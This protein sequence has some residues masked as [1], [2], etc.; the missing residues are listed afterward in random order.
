MTKSPTVRG[1]LYRD[2]ASADRAN[3]SPLPQPTQTPK[4]PPPAAPAPPAPGRPATTSRVPPLLEGLEE[5]RRRTAGPLQQ[6]IAEVIAEETLAARFADHEGA[7]A[8]ERRARL[9]EAWR[10]DEPELFISDPWPLALDLSADH[11][12]P[13]APT[14]DWPV[15]P[16]GDA[17]PC[18]GHAWW[19]WEDLYKQLR[20]VD[21]WMASP[22]ARRVA[23]G[24]WALY[25]E[26]QD[27]CWYFARLPHLQRWPW[28]VVEDDDDGLNGF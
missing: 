21:C 19:W 27:G 8:V 15:Q 1:L 4:E 16:A 25:R 10:R 5:M 28:P 17:R 6:A 24:V 22:P 7:L 18:E 3:P 13:V 2:S 12:G 26:P 14:V 11:D 20:C 9:L 23:R